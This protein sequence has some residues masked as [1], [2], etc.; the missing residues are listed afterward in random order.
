MEEKEMNLEETEVKEENAIDTL[1]KQLLAE[2]KDIF[3][4]MTTEKIEA[5][6]A[7]AEGYKAFLDNG[8]TERECVF[9]AEKML[10]A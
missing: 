6:Y 3:A 4:E 2:K 8:K 7:Y 5:A 9:E 10:E 1:K